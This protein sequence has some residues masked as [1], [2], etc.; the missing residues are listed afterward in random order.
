[1]NE[2]EKI[3]LILD[4]FDKCE[5]TFDEDLTMDEMC[6]MSINTIWD[7]VEEMQILIKQIKVVIEL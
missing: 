2:K 6:L 5:L 7:I 1:M 4:A 3:E